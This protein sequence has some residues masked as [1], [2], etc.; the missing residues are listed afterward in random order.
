MVPYKT[1]EGF[2]DLIPHTFIFKVMDTNSASIQRE[3]A[4]GISPCQALGLDRSRSVNP[5]YSRHSILFEQAFIVVQFV[6]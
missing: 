1:L 4:R 5:I 6:K 2:P 3:T